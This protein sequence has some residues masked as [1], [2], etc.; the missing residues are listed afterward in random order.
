MVLLQGAN[1]VGVAVNR[2][3]IVHDN[4]KVEVMWSEYVP[5]W[6]LEGITQNTNY[7]TEELIAT[8]QGDQTKVKE[9]NAKYIE[10][11]KTMINN[12]IKMRGGTTMQSRGISKISE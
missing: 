10:F 5:M 11:Q 4:K 8:I 7:Q 6:F 9:I 1:L 2:S 12:M 3:D